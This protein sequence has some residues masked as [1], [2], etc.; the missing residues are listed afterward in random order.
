RSDVFS[1]GAMLYEILCC[2][3]PWT[4]QQ[5]IDLASGIACDLRP[6]P[7]RKFRPDVPPE[8]EALVNQALE[9]DPAQRPT[10]QQFAAALAPFVEYAGGS[11]ADS[12]G[13]LRAPE[14]AISTGLHVPSP[15][16][17]TGE[18]F[19]MSGLR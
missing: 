12:R 13:T 11:T 18:E 3:S 4:R 8:L 17:D 16:T 6:R 14:G 9:W 19:W 15:D 2:T 1:L 5:Q 10:A 7:L